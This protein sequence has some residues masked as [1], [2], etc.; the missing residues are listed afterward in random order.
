[1][2]L[3]SYHFPEPSLSQMSNEG[4]LDVIRRRLP[5]AL[6]MTDG[7]DI[8]SDVKIDYAQDLIE[9]ARDLLLERGHV[10]SEEERQQ[11]SFVIWP[12]SEEE[13]AE[14]A[15]RHEDEMAEHALRLQAW[16]WLR[17]EIRE[18][19]RCL[20]DGVSLPVDAALDG[21]WLCVNS[22]DAY[23]VDHATAVSMRDALVA[24]GGVLRYE[25]IPED[26]AL[27]CS[28][29]YFS[30]ALSC[31]TALWA[32]LKEWATEGLAE[33]GEVWDFRETPISVQGRASSGVV[34]HVGLTGLL[35]KS[36]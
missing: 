10:F 20:F 1:M 35:P 33:I 34:F 26:G 13:K 36:F 21:L 22:S 2:D 27:K 17:V 15:R 31:K 18:Y 32:L 12:L 14:Q 29:F 11:M 5:Q 4:L 9:Q 23:R 16:E 7:S 3:N 6:D 25:W 19:A 8:N 30:V 28:D 24:A